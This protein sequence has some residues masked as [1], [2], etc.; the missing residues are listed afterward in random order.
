MR[1]RPGERRRGGRARGRSLRSPREDD[2]R[3]ARVTTEI[4][5]G[6]NPRYPGGCSRTLRHRYR[7][8]DP[9]PSWTSLKPPAD[10][11]HT[12]GWIARGRSGRRNR[13]ESAAERSTRKVACQ[14]LLVDREAAR[15]STETSGRD[16]EQ[17]TMSERR[18]CVSA[19]A[20]RTI[21]VPCCGHVRA[22]NCVCAR[23]RGCCNPSGTTRL[24]SSA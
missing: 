2:P 24:Y 4:T 13:R 18:A 20:V 11:V 23:H 8:C 5:T 15:S 6:C 1:G 22:S 16:L 7:P 19:A 9:H 14:S 3:G 21:S 12:T 17:T 10:D